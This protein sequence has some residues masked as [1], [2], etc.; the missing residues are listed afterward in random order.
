MKGSENYISDDI[1]RSD[2]LN[3]I[4][5]NKIEEN[6]NSEKDEIYRNNT[7]NRFIEISIIY[8]GELQSNKYLLWKN[9]H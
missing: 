6:I 2:V 4:F 3:K 8:K 9:Y 5:E 7:F 1:F